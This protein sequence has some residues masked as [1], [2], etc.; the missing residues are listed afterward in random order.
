MTERH[1]ETRARLSDDATVAFGIAIAVGAITAWFVFSTHV[2]EAFPGL[3]LV[4]SLASLAS[5]VR[6][7]Q[8]RSRQQVA[9]TWQWVAYVCGLIAVLLIGSV[10][11]L[12]VGCEYESCALP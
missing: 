10:V 5:Y 2:P 8:L 1:N 3:A 4:P 9:P 7:L 6:A 11:I 12:F